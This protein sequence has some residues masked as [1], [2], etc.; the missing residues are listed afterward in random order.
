MY[1]P[2]N[3]FYTSGSAKPA[4]KKKHFEEFCSSKLNRLTEMRG[5][6]QTITHTHIKMEY[7]LTMPIV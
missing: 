2:S 7:I 5:E 6:Q 4:K 1:L 3:V